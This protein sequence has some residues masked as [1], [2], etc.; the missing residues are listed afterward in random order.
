[1]QSKMARYHAGGPAAYRS[2]TG[3]VASGS[4]SRARNVEGIV[5]GRSRTASLSVRKKPVKQSC[6]AAARRWEEI[7]KNKAVRARAPGPTP[8]D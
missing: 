6:A 7:G 1:V 2:A 4:I 5:P 8:A 3:R